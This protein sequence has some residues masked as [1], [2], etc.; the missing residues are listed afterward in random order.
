MNVTILST[1]LMLGVGFAACTNQS[2]SDLRTQRADTTVNGPTDMKSLISIIEIPTADFTRAVA[3]YQAILGITIE[4]AEMDG[5]KIGLFPS[6][7]EGPFVQLINGS[8]YRPSTDGTVVY[9]NGRDDLQGIAD[10][11]EANGGKIVV[12][13]T[14]MGPEMGF[15]AIFSDSEGNKVGLYSS[16]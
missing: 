8:E 6:S 7:G 4:E 9:L 3:F 1:A 10:K 15:F 11:I 5:V 13:K 16:N 2:N 14:G 12:P